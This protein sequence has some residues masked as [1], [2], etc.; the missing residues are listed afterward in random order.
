MPALSM[1]PGSGQLA[2][3][4]ADWS[5]LHGRRRRRTCVSKFGFCRAVRKQGLTTGPAS[6]LTDRSGGK[7]G[8]RHGDVEGEGVGVESVG[9]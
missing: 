3:L 4:C 2:T 5:E 7:S 6:M 9:A 1:C 8:N